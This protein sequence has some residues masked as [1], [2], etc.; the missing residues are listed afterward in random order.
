MR[1]GEEA[2]KPHER[3]VVSP[4]PNSPATAAAVVGGQKH[5]SENS[6]TKQQNDI[7]NLSD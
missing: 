6:Y 5:L 1:A 7:N 4:R 3:G 2:K